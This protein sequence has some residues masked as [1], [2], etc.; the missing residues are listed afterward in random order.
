[1]I[2]IFTL[3]FGD[4]YPSHMVNDLYLTIKKYHND[5]KFYCYTDDSLGLVNGINVIPLTINDTVKLH[6]YKMD[7]FKDDFVRY[8]DNDSVIVMDIDQMF[9]NDPTP[10]LDY[11]VK[12]NHI[13]TTP[14]WWVE[15]PRHTLNGG[16]YKFKANT[17]QYVHD[18]F[19][20]D[21]DKWQTYY[22]Y[23]NTV[24]YLY[25]G[26]QNFV[27]D[28]IDHKVDLMPAEWSCRAMS[29]GNNYSLNLKYYELTK[30]P[31]IIADEWA[32]DIK[33][34]HYNGYSNL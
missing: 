28:T 4:R 2:H 26:E 15:A 22:F 16:W 5:F 14:R 21:P 3:K 32:P 18:K 9:V 13:A 25:Y 7:F 17:M 10:M 29:D 20:S 6:W 11:K 24:S 34:V 23:N 30:E 1:M 12:D 33:L 8:G 19:Y 27:C 31:M